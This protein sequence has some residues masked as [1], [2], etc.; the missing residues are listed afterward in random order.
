LSENRIGAIGNLR[1]NLWNKL[2]LKSILEF[3]D[4]KEFGTFFKSNNS[5]TIEPIKDYFLN[6]KVNLQSAAPSFNFLQNA[7]IYKKFNYNF[8]NFSNE[9]RTEIGG[10]LAMK[11]FKTE[12]FASYFRV[13]NFSYFDKDSMP[14]QSSSS[15]NIAQF[16]GDATFSF[17]KFNLNTRLL[18]Q[19]TLTNKD[20]FPAPDFVA[21]M[22]VFY[23]SKAFKNAAEIQTGLKINYFSKFNSR[24]FFPVLNEFILPGTSPFTIGG[25]PIVDAYF[26]MKVK[27]MFFFIEAQ[28]LNTLLSK[29]NTF[30]A[31][32]YPYQDFRINIGI[33]WHLIN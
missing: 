28:H 26:N 4:G 3:S 31:P 10:S 21:R 12:L 22:N 13:D 17:K 9:N 20:L 1:I 27:R 2:D 6:A 23:Q 32:N 7:S 29:N 19:N 14:K 8:T 18:Y 24:E 30:T 16:G 25:E 5:I 11:W 15:V 33:V